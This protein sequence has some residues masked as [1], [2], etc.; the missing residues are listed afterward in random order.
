MPDQSASAPPV[1]TSPAFRERLLPGPGAWIVLAVL[2]ATFGVILVPLS[3]YV[4]LVVGVL[5]L[6]AVCVLV[7]VTSPVLEVRDGE[8]V[9]GRAR[10][11]AHLLGDPVVLEGE[12]WARAMGQE[13]EPMAHHCTRG[14]IH[15]G[16]RSEVL[17]EQD[18]TTAWVASSRRPEDLAL[19][20]RAARHTVR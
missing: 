5:A 1:S 2:G 16:I 17:D 20:L 9:M 8:F 7:Y 15:A 4:A 3:P 14:W 6:I 10:I 12:D 13:F 18:P 11:P 19:A